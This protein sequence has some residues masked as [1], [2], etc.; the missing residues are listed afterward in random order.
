[1]KNRDKAAAL[2]FLKT[3]MKRHGRPKT[4]VTDK[5][6][7]YG[8]A[9]KEIGNADTEATG[10]WLNNRA[11]NSHQPLPKGAARA[12]W[13]APTDQAAARAARRCRSAPPMK[14]KPP[15]SSAHVAGSATLATPG[16]SNWPMKG[17]SAKSGVW[18]K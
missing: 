5:L 2:T 6:R 9:M 8:A 10:R 11:E 16:P 17:T 7:S 13:P 4:I 1:M 12:G 14:P 3:M 18:M 15:I